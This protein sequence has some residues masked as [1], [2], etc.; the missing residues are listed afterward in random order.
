MDATVEPA[1]LDNGALAARIGW[2]GTAGLFKAGRVR[3]EGDPAGAWSLLNAIS[4]ASRHIEWA[5]P[6]ANGRSHGIVLAPSML[7]CLSP[8]P[9]PTTRLSASR[10]LRHALDDLAA[11]GGR[12]RPRSR[13]FYR[14]EYLASL[15][16]LTNVHSS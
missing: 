5:V 14:Q 10:L 3:A 12:A 15:K 16:S 2:I 9:G 13:V 11:A 1:T 4:R 8:P 6:T 7:A